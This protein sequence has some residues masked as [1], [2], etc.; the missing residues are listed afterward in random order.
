M[1]PGKDYYAALG[2]PVGAT[3][4][5]I[6]K[7]F[8]KAARK[9]H[10]DVNPGD[11]AAEAKFKEINEAHEVLRDPK[12]R[13][14]YDAIR[15]GAGAGFGG[16]GM[17]GAGT[18]GPFYREEIFDLGDLLGGLFGG[19]GAGFGQGAA[20]GEDL[21]VEASVDFLDMA[22]GAV[23]EIS[24]RRPMACGSCG[25]TGRS[26]RRP[27]PSCGG[28]GVTGADETLKVRIPAGARDGASIRIPGRG[29][30]TAPGRSGD[31]VVRLRMLPHPV[32]RRSGND[33]LVDLP[34]HFSEA[35]RGAKV[36]V[37]TIDG[38]VTMTIPRGAS[39]GTKLR[40]RGKGVPVPGRPG[41]G[42]Q[43][44]TLQVA[45]PK[46]RSEEFLRLVERLSEFEDPNLRGSWN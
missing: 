14:E 32:F 31:L 25:G 41:R 22:R 33:I 45:V 26:G 18:E 37:P 44:V 29:A 27:C 46:T 36:K 39:S 35:V 3:D 4:E 34:V 12:R 6:R 21:T 38:P 16:R 30:E 5:E 2:V 13:A 11:R 7:A 43:Y 24:F 20:R 40:L 10:P 17:G 19:G 42:D 8:R 9:F 1:D 28:S 23:R 15:Q